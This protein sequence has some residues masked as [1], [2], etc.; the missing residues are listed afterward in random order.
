MSESFSE[1]TGDELMLLKSLLADRY[2]KAQPLATSSAALADTIVQRNSELYA[3]DLQIEAELQQM[4]AGVDDLHSGLNVVGA[5]SDDNNAML[6]EQLTRLRQVKAQ[7]A[8]Q[9]RAS[10][11]SSS[12]PSS[13]AASS[14][15]PSSK[16]SNK[17]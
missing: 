9:P 1:V 14:S 7:V 15:S 4:V 10:P 5:M 13:L 6:A 16:S 11:P 17:H 12:S 8:L 2:G 3:R